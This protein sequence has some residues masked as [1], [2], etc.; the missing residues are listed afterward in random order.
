MKASLFASSTVSDAAQVLRW[1]SS[2]QTRVRTK[3]GLARDIR[4]EPCLAKETNIGQRKRIQSIHGSIMGSVN[5]ETGP[6]L[7]IDWAGSCLTE[8]KTN[9][10]E[11]LFM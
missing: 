8:D 6:C 4:L 3:W 7:N 11:L 1:A 10:G 9:I 5:M 2:T